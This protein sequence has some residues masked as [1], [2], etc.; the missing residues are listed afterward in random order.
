MWIQI[1]L[2]NYIDVPPL[3]MCLL[4]ASFTSWKSQLQKLVALSSTEAEY[5]A[6]T[7]AIRE[8]T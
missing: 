6:S 7:D 8:G 2:V 5:I 3:H 4:L 1:F